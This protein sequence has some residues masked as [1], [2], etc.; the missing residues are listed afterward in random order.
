MRVLLIHQ[1]FVGRGEAGGTR[2]LEFA[3]RLARHGD[4]MIVVASQ[5]SYLT[6]QPVTTGARRLVS[7]EDLDGLTVLRAYALSFIHRN[8]VWRV[9]GFVVFMMS[10][11]Y[12]G[13]RSGPV[14]VVVGTSPPLP[15]AVSAWLVARLRRKPFVLEVR[16]LWPEFAIG[17]GVL[18]NRPLI[19]LARMLEA[20]VYRRADHIIVNSP[21]YQM[22]IVQKGRPSE[23]ISV[24]PNGVDTRMFVDGDR[25][26]EIRERLSL[27]DEFVVTY[28][29]AL[30]MAN[31]IDTIIGAAAILLDSPRIRFVLAG[32]GKERERLQRLVLDQGLSN[33]TFS[34]VLPKSEIPALLAASD[35]C[36]AT[37]MNIPMFTTTYPNKVFD[38][39]AAGRPTLL[40]IDGVIR[41]VLE[42]ANGGIFVPPGDAGALAAAI[43]QLANDPDQARRMGAA[44]RAYVVDHFDRDDQAEAFRSI[45]QQ[46]LASRASGRIRR[47]RVA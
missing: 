14:D 20:F 12:A 37:L 5:V 6:G 43:V 27:G 9:L 19:V 11:L 2:H 39:M 47:A 26:L 13:L 31:D 3:E 22:Y 23:S 25:A 8:F 33:V 45:L 18:R 24:V 10:S 38:Y 21:A 29:G 1:A 15:Q 7:R 4:H 42:A 30:G 44:A 32:D 40:A 28:A 41:E 35:A 17:M 36:I 16:D 34:G 46:V